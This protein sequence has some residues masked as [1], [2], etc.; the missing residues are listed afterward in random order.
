MTDIFLQGD[1]VH[2]SFDRAQ[3]PEAKTVSAPLMLCSQEML[4]P[5]RHTLHTRM[6]IGAWEVDLEEVTMEAASLLCV[7][8]EV[9]W[10][11]IV[12]MKGKVHIS[13]LCKGYM[14]IHNH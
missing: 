12:Y 9:S 13:T 14:D 7:A 3:L 10:R 8:V 5:D 6:L 2:I 1:F 11:W 4:L